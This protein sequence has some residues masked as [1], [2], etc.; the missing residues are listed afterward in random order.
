[1]G[2]GSRKPAWLRSLKRGA[3]RP[4][5]AKDTLTDVDIAT[6]FATRIALTRDQKNRRNRTRKGTAPKR[7]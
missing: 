2:V 1:M 4:R 7:I 5:P 6:S 3:D